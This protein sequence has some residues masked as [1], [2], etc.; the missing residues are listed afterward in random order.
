MFVCGAL[1]LTVAAAELTLHVLL[2]T[3]VLV[4]AL[5]VLTLRLITWYE[6]NG[7]SVRG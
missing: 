2:T 5:T 7:E 4:S 3:G 1:M 6:P